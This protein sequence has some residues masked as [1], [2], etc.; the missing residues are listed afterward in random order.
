[1]PEFINDYHATLYETL[2]NRG[3]LKVTE[4]TKN[5]IVKA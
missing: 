2:Q 3:Y 4:K 1:M 5:K